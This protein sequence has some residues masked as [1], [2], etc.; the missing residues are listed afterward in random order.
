MSISG[1]RWRITCPKPLWMDLSFRIFSPMTSTKGEHCW[2]SQC[3]WYYNDVRSGK[4]LYPQFISLINMCR[5]MS[6]CLSFQHSGDTLDWL[7][8]F[9]L[10]LH[11]SFELSSLIPTCK[12][13]YSSWPLHLP[14][15]FNSWICIL[16]H[17]S[18]SII[19]VGKDAACIYELSL[20][21]LVWQSIQPGEVSDRNFICT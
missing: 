3:R 15:S 18:V 7:C 14:W 11:P 16:I 9:F 21:H 17:T 1:V 19:T 6:H 10:E 12:P 2:K 4:D 5:W 20:W 13:L 8:H